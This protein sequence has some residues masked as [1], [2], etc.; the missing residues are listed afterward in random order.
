MKFWLYYK[1]EF[2]RWF[3]LV[4]HSIKVF[5][6]SATFRISKSY[7]TLYVSQLDST[8]SPE[9]IIN[10]GFFSFLTEVVAEVSSDRLCLKTNII[11]CTDFILKL[12]CFFFFFTFDSLFFSL[13]IHFKLTIVPAYNYG[14]SHKLAL[15]VFFFSVYIKYHASIGNMADVNKDFV[16]SSA[17]SG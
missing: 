13:S 17:F 2:L 9:V 3:C 8:I 1:M 6:Y 4:T 16:F 7:V 14:N 12:G 5:Q 11:S 15:L 10:L